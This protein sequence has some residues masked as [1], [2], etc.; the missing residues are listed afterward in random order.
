DQRVLISRTPVAEPYRYGESIE[1]CVGQLLAEADE[2]TLDEIEPILILSL[3]HEQLHQELLLTDIKHVLAQN[4][5]YPVFREA[6]PSSENA[7][8]A[9]Q[10]FIEFDEVIATIGHD[11]AGF[12]YDNE[13]PQHR[14][15]VPRFSL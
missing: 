8:V 9:P 10:R 2:A 4:P 5:L 1:Q 7:S 14:A 12:S 15:L 3:N 6:A 11:G 13:S